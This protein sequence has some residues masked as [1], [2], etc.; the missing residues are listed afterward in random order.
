MPTNQRERFLFAAITVLITVH[1]YVFY[2]IFICNGES[3]TEYASMM[4]ARSVP[5][6][7]EAIAV[8]GGIS[9]FG[10]TVPVWGVVILEFC[11]AL[12]LEMLLGQPCSVRLA[13]KVFDP[14][15]THPVLMETAIICATVGLMCPAMS[16]IA[17]FLYFPY[18]AMPLTAVNLLVSWAELLCL[19]FPFAFFTQL[20]FIQP[21]V[22][23][24]FRL[25]TRRRPEAAEAV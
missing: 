18:A 22:R 15:K 24:L 25:L 12:T 14:Q 1:A 6:V 16:L 4:S 13:M 5:T 7:A 2:S 3:L 10:T 20:F 9:V 21:L 19:N 8:L 17:A 11:C 23:T